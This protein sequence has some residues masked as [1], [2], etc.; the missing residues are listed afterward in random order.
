MRKRLNEILEP[1]G[2][3][4]LPSRVFDI[5]LA[6]LILV[7]VFGVVLGSMDVLRTQ[8]ASLLGNLRQISLTLFGIEYLLRVWTCPDNASGRFSDP[9]AGR[10][11]YLTSPL[12]LIDLLVLLFYYLP[13][14]IKSDL[15]ILRVFRVWTL[16]RT[17]RNS[18]PLQ[19]LVSVA[20][21]QWRTVVALV[22]IM[23]SLLLLAA[24]L[25]Y[26]VE[27]QAQPDAF[28]SIPAAL[29]WA[30]ATF[31]TVGYG[32]VIPHTVL[33]KISGMFIMFIGIAM[34]AIP[35]GII[36][37]GFAQELK[38]KDFIATWK[39]VAHV[40]LFSQLDVQDIAAIADLL[41]IRTA[42]PGEIIIQQGDTGDAMYFI[43][44]G[45]VEVELEGTPRRLR[46]GDFF[47]ELALLYKR[48][49]NAT[50]RARTF[51]ELLL[52]EARDF[53]A[54]IESQPRLREYI[55]LAA[56]KREAQNT[57]MPAEKDEKPD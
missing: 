28:G 30:M 14:P 46:D 49:R 18:W 22:I 38:R 42:L 24:S 47:G 5:C 48:P 10:L 54:F 34:F 12:M 51:T 3:N 6:A 27:R 57:G 41:H 32:D 43:A 39:L 33:G 56:Q 19:I 37:T 8:L 4:D 9:V 45:E 31:T 15:R 53:E 52:L 21:R 16:L 11:R 35:T 2:Y 23:L 25:M 44:S 55:T 20:G 26:T 29:W 40:P 36:V 50:V 17:I 13:V 1:A 7:N